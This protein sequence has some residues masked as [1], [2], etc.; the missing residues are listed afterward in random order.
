M[1]TMK[2]QVAF[3]ISLVLILSL[4]SLPK[5]GLAQEINDYSSD[6]SIELVP[7]NPRPNQAVSAKVVSYQL[8]I[9]RSDIAWIFN[10]KTV[11]SG[12]GEKTADFVLPSLGQESVLTVSIVTNEGVKTSKTK[13]FSGSDI[14]FL[15]QA[16]TSV[17][18]GYK[19]KA[20]AGRKAYVKI[21]ALPHLYSAS[22]AISR[23]NLV[24]DWTFNYKNLPDDS[25]MNR[26]TLLTRL[27]DTGDYVIGVK[28]STKDKMVSAQKYLHLSAEGVSPKLVFYADDP[29]EGPF[30]TK[31]IGNKITLKTKDI[32]IRAEPYFFNK[33]DG[34]TAYS[35]SMNG[36][37]I[38]SGKKPNTISLVSEENSGQAE[39]SFEMGKETENNLQS[40]KGRINIAF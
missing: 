15:W 40:A 10:G 2:K 26:N 39:I 20:L 35:W 25:G 18:A 11:A 19:G 29:L 14:D 5:N 30:Y 3:L 4:F 1:K 6:F 34:K 32:N 16:N 12:T 27:N 7:D 38:K 21:T 36:K 33:E 24:Y 31:S 28:V 17:P 9:N 23:S 37:V 8:D 22:G 13:K